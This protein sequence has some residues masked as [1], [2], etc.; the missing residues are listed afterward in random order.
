MGLDLIIPEPLPS[1]LEHQSC[2]KLYSS[3]VHSFVSEKQINVEQERLNSKL[4]FILF[5]GVYAETYQ[6]IFVFWSG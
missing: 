5:A 1:K 6:L 4:E 2:Q 3:D